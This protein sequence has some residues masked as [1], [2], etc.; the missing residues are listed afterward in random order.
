LALYEQNAF[1]LIPVNVL[2][3]TTELDDNVH[4][5]KRDK[6]AAQQGPIPKFNCVVRN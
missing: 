5:S 6:I 3:R 2:I 1:D 4:A